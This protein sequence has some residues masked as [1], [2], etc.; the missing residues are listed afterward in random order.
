M[1]KLYIKN[2]V[3]PRC[4]RVVRE[5]LDNLHLPVRDV[6]LGEVTIDADLTDRQTGSVKTA[7]EANG[8]ELIED[9]RVRLIEK[10]K[11][12]VLRLVQNDYEKNPI[13]LKDSAF[14]AK[15]LGRDYH[16]LSTLF[17]SVENITV[18]Q[19]LIIQRIER[20]KELLKYGDLTLTEISYKLGYSSIAH[21]SNQFKKITGMS[22]TAFIKLRTGTRIP[23]DQV[24]RK[25]QKR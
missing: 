13:A 9:E 15:E 5:E 17:S 25:T 8:F 18:E 6:I 2:M 14:I 20:V 23:I 12:A 10:I 11:H 1:T 4:I 22:P 3:C 19:Y 21:L 7:L 24:G 16:T